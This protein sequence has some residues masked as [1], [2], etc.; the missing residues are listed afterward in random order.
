MSSIRIL[1]ADDFED[2]RRQVHLLF[3]ARPQWQIIAEVSDGS[4]AVQKV[5]NLKP[6]LVVLDIGLPKLNGIEAARQI[7][8]FSPTSTIV[9]LS[10]N[11][12]SDVVRAAL[13]TG[14]L[15]YVHKTDAQ[16][17]LLPA[18]DA[19]LRGKQ[20][21]SSS[22]KGYE[23]TDTSGEKAPDC[24]EVLFYSDDT[25]L[26]DSVTRFIAAPL[27]A[28]NAAIVLATKSH[29]D[30]LLQRLKSEGVDTDGVLEQG[31]Y[32]SL[33]AADTLS[34]IMVN[35]L[36]DPVLFFRGI[37]GL[38]E[39]A[40]KAAKSKQPQVVV[41]GEA[42]ALLHAEGKADAA[43]RFEQL[44][45]DLA[46]THDVDI[47]CAYPLRSFHGEEDEHVFRRICAEHSAVYSG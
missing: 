45:N 1:V 8:Q 43:I 47:L 6:D 19:V 22:L 3:R 44:G 34:T 15:G 29:R 17:E 7:R 20:F 13:S 35:S 40:A 28:G 39:A 27:K 33:D 9:F 32:I 23:F 30:S 12:D 5:A 41:F 14:A 10:Q 21:V 24:H 37:G 4:E 38:I 11:N 26:L 46:K 25:V 42:V 18:V 16:S 2:W 31:T 36:P